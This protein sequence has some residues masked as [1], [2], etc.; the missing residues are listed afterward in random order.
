LEFVAD[1]TQDSTRGIV[2]DK[3]E[4]TECATLDGSGNC[5]T[6]TG[7]MVLNL[8]MPGQIW[9]SDAEASYNFHRWYRSEDG[10]YLV[11][12]PI[13]LAGGEP[14]YFGYGAVNPSGS[15]DPDGLFYG[16]GGR[17]ENEREL[18]LEECDLAKLRGECLAWCPCSRKPPGCPCHDPP[19]TGTAVNTEGDLDIGMTCSDCGLPAGAT[20]GKVFCFPIKS[21][22]RQTRS[23]S[24]LNPL[25]KQS[26]RDDANKMGPDPP[27]QLDPRVKP[28]RWSIRRWS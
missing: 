16:S 27:P 20:K 7:R 19:R 4:Y 6:P 24:A 10:R 1:N 13:G 15:A 11:P 26:L 22:Q 2:I 25:C 12:D 17:V 14:G 23:C 21:I 28:G 5:A 18:F 9:D 3:V 8:R